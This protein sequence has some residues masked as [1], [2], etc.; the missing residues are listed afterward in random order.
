MK[1]FKLR[2]YNE[3]EYFVVCIYDTLEEMRNAANKFNQDGELI[4]DALAI[5][6]PYTRV[7]IAEDGTETVINDIGTIRLVK[8]NLQ[9]HIV[10]H[11]LV[12][13]AMHHYR[14]TQPTR[15]ANFGRGNGEAEENFGMIYAKYFSKMSRQLYKHGFWK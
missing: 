2:G 9:T 13:A 5:C 10:S 7:R 6:Q 8:D 14:L 3:E 1:K 12:H 4:T 15:R 11:E